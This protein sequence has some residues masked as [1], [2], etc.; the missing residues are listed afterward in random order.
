MEF[1]KRL[2]G[3]TFSARSQAS[4][5]QEAALQKQL[6]ALQ[7]QIR[8]SQ[9]VI[10]NAQAHIEQLTDSVTSGESWASALIPESAAKIRGEKDKIAALEPSRQRI[11]AQIDAL[12]KPSPAEMEARAEHQNALS[13]LALKRLEVDRELAKTCQTLCGILAK[14]EEMTRRMS[15]ILGKIDLAPIDLDRGRLRL[16][17]TPI[18]H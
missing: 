15:G 5:R 2:K 18:R 1:L 14:R 7:E 3:K 12:T 16:K 10:N 13:A 9:H 6:S 17:W 11:Q 4:Y 8:Q